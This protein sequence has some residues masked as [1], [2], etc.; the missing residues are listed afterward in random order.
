MV[1]VLHL[2]KLESPSPKDVLCQ[3]WLNWPIGSGEEDENFKSLRQQQ[4]Q[5]RR[6]RR[7]QILIRKAHRAFG[8]RELKTILFICI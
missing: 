7:R 2:F 3:V 1:I 4:R 5:R 8:S 6:Q